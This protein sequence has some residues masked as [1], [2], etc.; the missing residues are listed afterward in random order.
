MEM[1][2]NPDQSCKKKC[3]RDMQKAL[4][5]AF[6]EVNEKLLKSLEA[7]NRR[8]N[9]SRHRPTRSTEEGL[10]RRDSL[11]IPWLEFIQDHLCPTLVQQPMI[12]KHCKGRHQPC[13]KCFPTQNDNRKF[14]VVSRSRHAIR[15]N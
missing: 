4:T 3:M 11:Q 2:V 5:L 10:C 13:I 15:L 14:N 8:K 12:Q 1:I 7:A 6:N 9:R